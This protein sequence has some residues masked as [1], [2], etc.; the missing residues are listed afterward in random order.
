MIIGGG[1]A[2]LGCARSLAGKDGVRVTLIDHRNYHQFQPLLYQVATSQLAA[3]G[4]ASPLRTPFQRRGER[5]RKAGSGGRSRP[6]GG[7]VSTGEGGDLRG[8]VL[9][10]A[11]G[12]QANFFNTPGA[13]EH[14]FPL[15]SLADAES[16]ARASSPSSRTPTATPLIDRGA[17]NFVIVGAGATGTELAGALAD[18]INET[19]P[20]EYHDL[21]VNRATIEVV[22]LGHVV[23]NGFS[24]KAHKYASK[25]LKTAA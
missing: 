9:V 18:M 11:A 3:T 15:Y 13:V 4:I 6:G 25:V 2:G 19:M 16:S 7:P 20:V 21:A 17:L 1:F 5:R 24:D 22:D 23:L 10:L 8:D 14:A 12:G